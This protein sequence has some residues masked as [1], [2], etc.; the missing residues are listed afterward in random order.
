MKKLFSVLA[1][2]AMLLVSSLSFADIGV[3][4]NGVNYGSATDINL[5]CGAGTNQQVITQGSVFNINCSPN[6]A[7]TGSAN[8]GAVSMVTSDLAVPTSYAFVRKAIAALAA[9]SFTAGTLAN[10][11]PGQ[12]LTF[13][14]TT[15][16]ASGT[17]TITPTTSTGFTSIQFST[18]KQEAIFLYVNDT[19]GW[20][21]SGTTGSPTVNIP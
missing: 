13:F 4:V 15:V 17:F 14:I 21:L 16:G 3:R 1:A 9:G 18:A 12:M 7:T 5:V 8:G 19:V 20:I 6:L 11:I 10:G 2:L